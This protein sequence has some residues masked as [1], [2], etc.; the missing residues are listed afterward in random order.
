MLYRLYRDVAVPRAVAD[1]FGEDLP[2]WLSV[3]RVTRRDDVASL[4]KHLGWGEAEA[5]VLAEET[6]AF[7]LILDDWKARRYAFER[8]LPVTGTVAVLVRAKQRLLIPSV[9][10]ALRSLQA[11]DFRVSQRL[12]D[13]ALLLA[14]EA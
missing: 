13:H 11:A 6:A 12:Y 2:E 4:R 1:E 5:I 7:R 9:Q 3:R 14:Q 8:S 10:E